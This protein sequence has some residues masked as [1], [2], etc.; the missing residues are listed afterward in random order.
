MRTS[1]NNT[2]RIERYL[3]GNLSASDKLVFEFQLML[4]PKLRKELYFQKKTYQLVQLYHRKKLKEEL[5]T[6]HQ[7]IFDDP[8][9]VVF[10]QA[11][12]RLFKS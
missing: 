7:Q 9:K 3:L 1:W 10:Q 5:E 6:L 2:Q 12:Y 11:I 8:D 4:R